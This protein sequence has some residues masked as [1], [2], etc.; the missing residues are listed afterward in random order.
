MMDLALRYRAEAEAWQTECAA[1][2]DLVADLAIEA[3]RLREGFKAFAVE[4]PSRRELQLRLA[5]T[6]R[7]LEAAEAELQRYLQMQTGG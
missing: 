5:A 6:E 3:Y 4:L 1:L 7:R 2:I